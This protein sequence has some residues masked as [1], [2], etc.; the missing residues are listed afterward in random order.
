MANDLLFQ[1][2]DMF[3]EIV[4]YVDFETLYN[5]LFVSHTSNIYTKP[6]F[7]R[8]LNGL[9]YNLYKPEYHSDKICMNWIGKYSYGS[10][11]FRGCQVSLHPDYGEFVDNKC[12]DN[13]N[14]KYINEKIIKPLENDI[15]FWNDNTSFLLEPDK[16]IEECIMDENILCDTAK[17]SAILNAY[18]IYHDLGSDDNVISWK[19]TGICDKYDWINDYTSYWNEAEKY[20]ISEFISDWLFNINQ[21]NNNERM[22]QLLNNTYTGT[23]FYG[24]FHQYII[25]IDKYNELLEE[26]KIVLCL[27]KIHKVNFP[28]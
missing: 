15:M 8:K 24:K 13:D 20:N 14:K 10:C 12:F 11:F 27:A 18:I 1:V 2:K 21:N 25:F 28:L 16:N 3:N 9:C 5:L 19:N 7:K 23:C 17:L 22:K 4:S 26:L 6:L